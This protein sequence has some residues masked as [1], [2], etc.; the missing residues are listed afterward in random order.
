M[1][2]PS[3]FRS[4]PGEES[5]GASAQGLLEQRTATSAAHLHAQNRALLEEI[6]ACKKSEQEARRASRAKSMFLAD[7]SHEIRTPLNAVLGYVQILAR[8]KGLPADVQPALTAM[9]ESGHHLLRLI[10][11]IL[12][13][14]KIEAG[15]MEVQPVDFDLGALLR[16]VHA[17][18]QQ[19]A[20]QEQKGLRLIVETLGNLPVWVRGDQGKLRSGAPQF[21]GQCGEVHPE[22]RRPAT[23]RARRTRR[24]L[25]LRGDRSRTGIVLGIARPDF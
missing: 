7:M 5:T 21:T 13:L 24:R 20:E 10:E 25:P 12:D 17:I 16:S 6:A 15:K 1:N 8:K 14:S 19:R 4:V 22:R 18:C 23:R 11:G 2:I 9:A 3:A